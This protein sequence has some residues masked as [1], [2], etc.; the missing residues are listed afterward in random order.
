VRAKLKRAKR[1]S[2]VK[3][4]AGRRHG[5]EPSERDAKEFIVAAIEESLTQTLKQ[6]GF[7]NR[8]VK[9][10]LAGSTKVLT[11]AVG[12]KLRGRGVKR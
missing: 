5:K 3:A 1:A 2:R 6:L 10:L 9:D 8:E 7:S 12:E 11:A 4:R